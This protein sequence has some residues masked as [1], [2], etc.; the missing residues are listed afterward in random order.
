MFAAQQTPIHRFARPPIGD[1]LIIVNVGIKRPIDFFRGRFMMSKRALRG[2]VIG[3]AVVI[4]AALLF[5]RVHPVVA[6]APANSAQAAVAQALAAAR[7]D[8]F[9]GYVEPP[10]KIFGR[11]MTLGEARQFVFGANAGEY[12][13]RPASDLVWLVVLEGKFV[14]HV[15]AAPPDIP[16]KDVAHSQMALFIDAISG[17]VFELTMIAPQQPL[18]LSTLPPLPTP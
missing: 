15:P 6:P 8:G 13:A 3:L 11:Q 10:E 9:G 7:D 14:E 1:Q 12:N 17:D 18:D 5:L 16:A 2:L 4:A